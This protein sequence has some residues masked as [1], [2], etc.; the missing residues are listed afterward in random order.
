MINK[1]VL[2]DGF[3]LLIEDINDLQEYTSQEFATLYQSLLKL[4]REFSIPASLQ[5]YLSSIAIDKEAFYDKAD[6]TIGIFSMSSSISIATND[7]GNYELTLGLDHVDGIIE[8]KHLFSA[9]NVRTSIVG[10]SSNVE[11]TE[12]Q[13]VLLK[14]DVEEYWSGYHGNPT[15]GRISAV[16]VSGKDRQHPVFELVLMSVNDFMVLND[17]DKQWYALVGFLKQGVYEDTNYDSAVDW[18]YKPVELSS[19][20]SLAHIYDVIAKILGPGFSWNDEPPA[21]LSDINLEVNAITES[22]IFFGAR[23]QFDYEFVPSDGSLFRYPDLQVHYGVSFVTAPN[24]EGA[25]PPVDD[26][27]R[28]IPL[29]FPF[30]VD[31]ELSELKNHILFYR[32]NGTSIDEEALAV[33]LES[34]EIKRDED[35]TSWIQFKKGGFFEAYKGKQLCIRHP[36]PFKGTFRVKPGTAKLPSGRVIDLTNEVQFPVWFPLEYSGH[37]AYSIHVREVSFDVGGYVSTDPY[38]PGIVK[39]IYSDVD[40]N[41]VPQLRRQTVLNLLQALDNYYAGGPFPSKWIP[42]GPFEEFAVPDAISIYFGGIDEDSRLT[43]Y[44]WSLELENDFTQ[45][46]YPDVIYYRGHIAVI[47]GGRLGSF[48]HFSVKLTYPVYDS[49]ARLLSAS[50]KTDRSMKL[51]NESIDDEFITIAALSYR[52]LLEDTAYKWGDKE[53]AVYGKIFHGSGEWKDFYLD[54][55]I[56]DMRYYLPKVHSVKRIQTFVKTDDLSQLTGTHL[57]HLPATALVLFDG[58]HCQLG[59]DGKLVVEKDGMLRIYAPFQGNP[60]PSAENDSLYIEYSVVSGDSPRVSVSLND[61]AEVLKSLPQTAGTLLRM[62]LLEDVPR[63]YQHID[64]RLVSDSKLAINGFL[65]GRDLPV[66]TGGYNVWGDASV[67][68]WLEPQIARW[69]VAYTQGTD[70]VLIKHGFS[71][72]DLVVFVQP[73]GPASGLVGKM[74]VE[75]NSQYVVLYNTGA[76]GVSVDVLILYRPRNI[77][78]RDVRNYGGISRFLTHGM[79]EQHFGYVLPVDLDGSALTFGGPWWTDRKSRSDWIQ[80]GVLGTG[81]QIRAVAVPVLPDSQMFLGIPLNQ[82]IIRLDHALGLN[83]FTFVALESEVDFNSFAIEKGGAFDLVYVNEPSEDK[84][85]SFLLLK[86]PDNFDLS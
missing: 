37:K 48:S 4:P 69:A 66:F 39:W 18:F 80:S 56:T 63:G 31:I 76:E 25:D 84:K 13:L 42:V 44:D 23:N 53:N 59:D 22:G 5:D 14:V 71:S 61:G 40:P 82:D 38:E 49:S 1:L 15:Y 46:V 11:I 16:G 78:Y 17:E 57:K 85:V 79:G 47:E 10:T 43:L 45:S 33:P 83:H 81:E 26:F 52:T 29:Q 60:A 54:F 74:W 30:P 32:V 67:A 50:V 68:Q 36:I 9:N 3:V 7:D 19:G 65:I 8:L 27:E 35:G 34:F 51:Y 75:I 70:G 28:F 64:L 58:E 12:G 21:T 24:Y 2:K 20:I 55:S 62:V 73:N 6:G 41:E 77:V 72:T 86:V